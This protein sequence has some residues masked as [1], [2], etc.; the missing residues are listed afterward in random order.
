MEGERWEKGGGG[1]TDRSKISTGSC[2]RCKI[3]CLDVGVLEDLSDDLDWDFDDDA[4]L[5]VEEEKEK[6]GREEGELRLSS[7]LR[8][9]SFL[10]S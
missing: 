6:E 5:R 7:L 8:R 2:H 3:C 10:F 9:C 4:V 1:G